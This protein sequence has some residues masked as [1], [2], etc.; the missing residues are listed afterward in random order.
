MLVDKTFKIEHL[1]GVIT[2]LE[3][4]LALMRSSHDYVE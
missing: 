4:D 1:I 3:N 2:A